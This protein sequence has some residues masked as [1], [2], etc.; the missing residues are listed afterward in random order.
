MLTTPS[1][2]PE[3]FRSTCLT[4]QIPVWGGNLTVTPCALP[5]NTSCRT[6]PIPSSRFT[7]LYPFVH[8]YVETFLHLW[9][10]PR[11]CPFRLVVWMVRLAPLIFLSF[12]LED[13]YTYLYIFIWL[14]DVCRYIIPEVRFEPSR[15]L[16][17]CSLKVPSYIYLYVSVCCPV[18]VRR[19]NRR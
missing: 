17:R 5:R 11:F 3:G 8:L 16:N 2:V 19:M 6:S 15:V 12:V 9:S 14:K 1:Y 7:I 13:F 18:L 10:Y 4:P